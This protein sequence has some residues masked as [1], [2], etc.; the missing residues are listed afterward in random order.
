MVTRDL[1]DVLQLERLTPEVL[2]GA[3][4]ASGDGGYTP[5]DVQRMHEELKRK[6]YLAATDAPFGGVLAQWVAGWISE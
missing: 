6:G 3:I 5:R 2:R 4:E 1:G